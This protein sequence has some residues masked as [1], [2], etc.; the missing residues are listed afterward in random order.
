M[1]D[2]NEFDAKTRTEWYAEQAL[3]RDIENRMMDEAY[4]EVE[5]DENEPE[6]LPVRPLEFTRV[7]DPGGA[8]IGKGTFSASDGLTMQFEIASDPGDEQDDDPDL[9]DG[10]GNYIFDDED[11][12]ENFFTDDS[13]DPDG[14][15]F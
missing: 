7:D 1:S 12:E 14:I 8:I 9:Y 4:Y 3:R 13:D 10:E 6:T 2:Y 11:D 5:V 15:P